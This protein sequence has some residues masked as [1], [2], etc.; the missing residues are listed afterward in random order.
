MDEYEMAI[1]YSDSS[2][3]HHNQNVNV[4]SDFICCP[5]CKSINLSIG[6]I[7]TPNKI[8][9]SEGVIIEF[10]CKECSAELSLA[11]FNE[12]A[13]NY[14]SRINWVKKVI[15]YSY[16]SYLSSLR[17]HSLT[18]YSKKFKE[19]VEKYNVGHLDMGEP[20]PEGVPHFGEWTRINKVK[21]V[22]SIRKKDK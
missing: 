13:H 20:L 9:K 12:V 7:S 16:N 8:M 17:S 19:Y 3:Q 11:L 15:P 14:C 4:E 22:V 1:G 6:K 21:N 2:G 18:G 5:K 10:T